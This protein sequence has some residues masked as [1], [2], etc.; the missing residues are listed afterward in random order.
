MVAFNI[1]S[2][3][4]E[5]IRIAQICKALEEKDITHTFKSLFVGRDFELSEMVE[6]VPSEKNDFL[7][8]T[9]EFRLIVVI[10]VV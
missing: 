7:L 9:L 1:T 2:A 6:F 5:Y 8:C 10:G 3:G 4:I